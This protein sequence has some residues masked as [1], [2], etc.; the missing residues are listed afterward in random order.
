M[1]NKKLKYGRLSDS[2]ANEIENIV[3]TTGEEI[4]RIAYKNCVIFSL[5]LCNDQSVVKENNPLFAIYAHVDVFKA[6][7]AK[8][9]N[10]GLVVCGYDRNKVI[11]EL[12]ELVVSYEDQIKGKA[13]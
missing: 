2:L 3:L 11:R 8:K 6:F 5:Y 4:R 10:G 12:A 9:E 13:A 7:G 1:K